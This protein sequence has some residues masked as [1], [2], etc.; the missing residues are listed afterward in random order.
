MPSPPQSPPLAAYTSAT[1]NPSRRRRGAAHTVAE[2]CE[3]L[4]CETLTA[5]FLGEGD[6]AVQDSLVTGGQT[7]DEIDVKGDKGVQRPGHKVGLGGLITPTA[8]P[9]A[10]M[11]PELMNTADILVRQWVEMFD[12]AGG[13]RF[14][15]FVASDGMEKT[16]FIFFDEG[17]NGNDLKPGLMA[18]LELCELPAFDCSK[19]VTCLDRHTEPEELATL[20]RDLGWVGFEPYTLVDWTQSDQIISDSWIFLSMDV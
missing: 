9:E 8:S 3:R 19:L 12:Y 10:L 7:Q 14:R 20:T 17:V 5:V 18:L 11:K 16:L 6:L 2:E 15:G 1:E 4:F 13:A